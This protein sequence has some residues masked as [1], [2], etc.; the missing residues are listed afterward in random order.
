MCV[1]SVHGSFLPTSEGLRQTF[2][3]FPQNVSDSCTQQNILCVLNELIGKT[4]KATF[5][6][7][8]R[9]LMNGLSLCM[10]LTGLSPSGHT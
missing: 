8:G 3:V 7:L 2:L 10:C 4:G 5:S 6:S 1:Q 9:N